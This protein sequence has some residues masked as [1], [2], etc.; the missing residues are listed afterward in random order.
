MLTRRSVRV[1]LRPALHT[2][3]LYRPFT[4]NLSDYTKDFLPKKPEKEDDSVFIAPNATV[5]G[6]VWL[7][8]RSSVW[9]QAVL[10]A[11]LNRIHIGRDTNI[12]DGVLIHVR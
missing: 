1:S 7:G 3:Y 9:Y 12:Q 6:P 11:D 2:R 4:S 10:R 8:Q 5:L